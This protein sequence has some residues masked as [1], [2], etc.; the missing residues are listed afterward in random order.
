MPKFSLMPKETRFFAYFEQQ[1]ENIVKMAQQLKD[2]IYIWQNIKERARVLADMEQDGDAITHDIMTLLNLSY[3]TPID[4]EDI[5]ALTHSLDDIADRIHAVA[6]TLYLYRIEQPTGRAKEMSDIIL[7]AALEVQTGIL[8]IK[9]QMRQPDLLKISE[10]INQIENSGDVIYK[11]ALAEL[12]DQPNDMSFI[13]KWREVY[14]KMEATI[15]GCEIFSDILE[16]IAI[17]YA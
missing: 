11:T 5:T 8:E 7:K 2:M 14:K 13:V 16:D 6:D 15:D 12:F 17:K 9:S 10:N 1:A 3:I 4:R